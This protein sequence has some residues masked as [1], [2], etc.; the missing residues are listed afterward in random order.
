MPAI[1][2]CPGSMSRRNGGGLNRIRWSLK[3]SGVFSAVGV[4]EHEPTL[5]IDCH[6]PS[7]RHNVVK[8]VAE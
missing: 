4:I 2:I 1:D 7:F 3:A 5:P 8:L 6:T